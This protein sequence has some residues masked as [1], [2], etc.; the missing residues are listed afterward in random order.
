MANL[1]DDEAVE[2]E[3]LVNSLGQ[4]SFWPSGKSIPGGWGR[5]FGPGTRKDAIRFVEEASAPCA[6]TVAGRIF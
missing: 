2:L 3:V 4:H 6:S 5:V 1:F